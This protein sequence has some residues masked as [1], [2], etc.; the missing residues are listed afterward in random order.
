VT[1]RR[2]GRA[3]ILSLAALSLAAL[4]LA[5]V[6]A[7]AALRRSPTGAAPR[8]P[9]QLAPPTPPRA[10]ARVTTLHEQRASAYHARVF[11]D[12]SGVIVTTPAGF[13]TIRPGV[14]PEERA[15]DLGSIAVSQGSSIVFWRAGQLREVAL[16]GAGERELA[17]VPSAPQYLL[18]DQGRLAWIHTD[19]KTGSTLHTLSSEG[20]RE[21]YESGGGVSACVM[22]GASVYWVLQARDG[23]WTI[24][25]VSLEGQ[26]RV[27]TA[28]HQGRPPAMLALGR[29]GV[30]F[31]AG[32]KRGVRKLGFDLAREDAVLSEVICSPIAVSSRVVC[33][34]VGGLFEIAPSGTAPRFLASEPS[35]PI[36][37]TAAT[38]DRAFWVAENGDG[39]L[40]VRTAPLSEL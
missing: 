39:G 35:G 13:T 21:V 29:D 17:A 25:R 15:F 4:S 40:V 5:G 28:A 7:W 8:E 18:A 23:S 33:A 11:A 19:R 1:L 10:P 2:G 20:V 30:Y 24:E 3:G 22:H 6:V 38:D 34:Q 12:E 14:T 26:P 16:S 32:P 36:A 31:Y 27:S 9:A 37:A